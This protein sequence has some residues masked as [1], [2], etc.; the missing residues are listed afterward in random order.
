[1]FA[2]VAA[3]YYQFLIEWCLLVFGN[4]GYFFVFCLKP[5]ANYHHSIE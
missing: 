1:M 2:Y 5:T 4:V 3:V